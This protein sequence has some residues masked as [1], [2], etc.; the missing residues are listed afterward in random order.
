MLF[1]I[2]TDFPAVTV[3]NSLCGQR[4][5]S[6]S[7]KRFSKRIVSANNRLNVS[8]RTLNREVGGISQ[9]FHG[10]KRN[11]KGKEQNELKLLVVSADAQFGC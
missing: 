8:S 7:C 11:M 1:I 4:D 2:N 9:S 10:D 5:N 6:D 3:I